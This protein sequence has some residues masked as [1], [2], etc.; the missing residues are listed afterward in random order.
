MLNPLDHA[1]ALGKQGRAV[2]FCNED[3]S[4]ACAKGCYAASCSEAD[5]RQLRRNAPKAPLLALSTG[6]R[7]GVDVLDIDA[8]TGGLDWYRIHAANIGATRAYMTRREGIHLWFQHHSGLK[9][10]VGRP[11]PGVDIRTTGGSAIYWPAAGLPVLNAAEPS[12]WPDWLLKQILPEQ[13]LY[14]QAPATNALPVAQG[15]ADAALRRA[16]LAVA[17]APVG[18]RNYTLN[19][20]AFGLLRFA[21]TGV[22]QAPLIAEYLARAA[23]YSGLN[24]N[25]ITQTLASA[26][27]ARGIA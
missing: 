16:T 19:R 8:P 2:F 1:L 24:R 5:I 7:S 21:Q 27:R 6:V 14:Y 26:L 15:Y 4:P 23:L 17:S 3:K 10:W 22:L 18:Q 25:E 12:P 11:A 13:R 9:N 20:E